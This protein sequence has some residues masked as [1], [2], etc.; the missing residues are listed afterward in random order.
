REDAVRV[1]LERHRHAGESGGKR[2]DA[3][4]TEARQR[5]VVLHQLAFALDD[6]DVHSRLRVREGGELLRGAGG[7]GGVAQDELLGQ[8]AHRLQTEAERRDVEQEYVVLR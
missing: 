3:G 1:H 4:E 6:V 7:D 8:A 5:A 2:R